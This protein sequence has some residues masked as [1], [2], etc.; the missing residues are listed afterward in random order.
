MARSLKVRKLRAGERRKL[1]QML[2]QELHPQQRRRAHVLLLHSE[3]LTGVEIAAG[4]QSHP[5]TIYQD[6]HAFA[7]VG[8][9]C[10]Q[11]PATGG[12]TKQLTAEQEAEMQR[13]ADLPPI[14]VGQPHGRWSLAK[15]RAY[16]LKA[17]LVK[18]ISREH[19]RRV[20][21]KGGCTFAVCGAS[22][23]API[24]ND[25]RF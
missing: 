6:L 22:W 24:R 9:A 8:L 5:Q 11:P 17:R 14:E 1:E 15:L 16:L 23:S 13:L 18:R 7:Q 10:L 3:R 2:M 4:L 20:L 25:S 12:A 21:K 19:L